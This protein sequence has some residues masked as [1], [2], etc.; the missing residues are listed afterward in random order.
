[1]ETGDE[2]ASDRDVAETM[3]SERLFAGLEELSK[4]RAAV[5]NEV[6]LSDV[7]DLE[8][9][10][11]REALREELLFSRVVPAAHPSTDTVDPELEGLD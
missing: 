11:A 10:D 2:S 6:D 8:E 4:C 7:P 9:V 5:R 3:R 1:V